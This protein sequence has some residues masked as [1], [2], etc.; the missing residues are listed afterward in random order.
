MKKLIHKYFI[1]QNLFFIIVNIGFSQVNGVINGN[2]ISSGFHFNNLDLN[3]RPKD[4]NFDKHT[5]SIGT[6]QIDFT[7]LNL[8]NLSDSGKIKSKISIS[9][10]D[11]SMENLSIK[12]KV[13][14]TDW[15]TDEKIKRLE[16]RQKVPKGSILKISDAIKL[17]QIDLGELPLSLND[18]H[19][20]NYINLD[21]PPFNDYGWSYTL[22]LPESIIA[23]TT[24]IN[25]FPNSKMIQYNYQTET[26]IT[27]PQIDSLYKIPQVKW[28]YLFNIKNI[29]T[30]FSSK[31]ELEINRNLTNFSVIMKRGQFKISNASFS[32]LP[33]EHLL[34]NSIIKLP[35][36]LLETNDFIAEGS[37]DDFPILHSLKGTF[38]LR[39][40]EIKIP[41]GLSD[42]PEIENY[43]ERLGIWNN[44][45][46]I[47]LIQIEINM[48]N[49]STGDFTVKFQTPFLKIL[50]VGNFSSQQTGS[51]APELTLHNTT[52]K[53]NPIAL[54]IRKWIRQWEKDN[55][56]L[57]RSG[58]T[59]ILDVEG[60]LKELITKNFW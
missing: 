56:K 3:W 10:P 6:F 42:E 9:G 59:I 28:E 47:R 16:R 23:N 5:L 14:S 50:A 29:S 13:L 2:L 4:N 39:N 25:P 45:F 11:L 19:I 58:A 20:N 12:S 44:S 57:K 37:I 27:P 43:L 55:Q 60:P 34:D 21:L 7:K 32:A 8:E 38:R 30:S 18:L 41:E 17:Y 52:I 40:F 26:F 24:Q 46:V 22:N 1:F 15:I 35:E 48:L 53:I 54:G 33:L 49:E 36:L 51:A 31:I